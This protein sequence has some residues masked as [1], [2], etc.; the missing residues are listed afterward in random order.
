MNLFTMGFR[1]NP[2]EIRPNRHRS[3]FVF[4]CP[5]KAILIYVEQMLETGLLCLNGTQRQKFL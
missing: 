5:P 2:A 3:R 4:I 1:L